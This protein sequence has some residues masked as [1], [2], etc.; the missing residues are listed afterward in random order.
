MQK[1]RELANQILKEAQ[2]LLTYIVELI[3]QYFLNILLNWFSSLES[4][5][6]NNIEEVF[7]EAKVILMHKLHTKAYETTYLRDSNGYIKNTAKLWA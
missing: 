2:N 5:A 3:N 4:F 6:Y 7:E 1:C